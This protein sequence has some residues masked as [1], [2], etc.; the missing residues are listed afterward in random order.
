MKQ[1]D[2][3]QLKQAGLLSEE[4]AAAIATHIKGQGSRSWQWLL[5]S[6]SS[7]AGHLSW[8]VLSC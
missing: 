5:V 8:V 4:Q 2:I 3:E 1:K 6:L 7:L